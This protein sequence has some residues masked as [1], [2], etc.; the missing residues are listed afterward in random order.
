MGGRTANPSATR[1]SESSIPAEP[2]A[3]SQPCWAHLGLWWVLRGER[4]T[5][6]K[7]AR[8]LSSSFLFLPKAFA[9]HALESAEPSPATSLSVLN[10]LQLLSGDEC[11]LTRK[12]PYFPAPSA[13]AGDSAQCWASPPALPSQG[14]P[15]VT[16]QVSFPFSPSLSLS[17]SMEKQSCCLPGFS[18]HGFSTKRRVPLSITG[19]THL[20]CYIDFGLPVMW[21]V[22]PAPLP[23]RPRVAE[24]GLEGSGMGS[25]KS[26]RGDGCI[27]L[28]EKQR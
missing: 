25:W 28:R 3:R 16:L 15:A 12:K 17:D 23:F 24:E 19:Q 13:P 9:V 7:G 5:L 1:G 21:E 20:W 14:W 27:L 11:A 10:L 6:L 4:Q 18:P 8:K 22:V 2:G 26:Q